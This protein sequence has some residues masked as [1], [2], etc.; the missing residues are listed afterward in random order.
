MSKADIIMIVKYV[1]FVAFIG[2]LIKGGLEVRAQGCF[3]VV[4][5][6]FTP[7]MGVMAVYFAFQVA[8]D[9]LF[10]DEVKTEAKAKVEA[11]VVTETKLPGEPAKKLTVETYEM[12]D[13][14][15]EDDEDGVEEYEME[16][17]E[18]EDEDDDDG[19][20]EYEMDDE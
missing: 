12:E 18:D 19:V 1:V 2:L 16:E 20:E 5:E 13:Y 17:D 3:S 6:A 15:D 11:K 10:K 9:V 14:E 8:N 4:T 7:A